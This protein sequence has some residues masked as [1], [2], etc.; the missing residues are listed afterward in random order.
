MLRLIFLSLLATGLLYAQLH[1]V[2]TTTTM[3][4]L[5]STVGGDRVKVT[6]LAS[7]DRDSHFLQARPSMMRDLRSAD[8]VVSVGAELEVGWLP[9][10][11]RGA[12]NPQ[13]NPGNPGYFE[14]ASQVDL[15]GAGQ[16]A[17]RAMGDVHPAGNPHINLDPV[18]LAQ[19][20][21][22]LAARLGALDPAGREPYR[23]NA[24]AFDEAVQQ[25]LSGWKQK[26]KGANGVLLY[27]K[28][29]NYLTSR[30]GVPVLGYVEPLPGIPPTAA[31][32]HDLASRLSGQKGAVLHAV[33]QP[34]QSSEFV[35]KQL[36]WPVRALP[37]DPPIGGD[38]EA[39]F[40][41]I[42]AWVDAMAL[43]K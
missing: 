37:T 16:A 42:D 4:M 20:A 21:M 32:L 18:R 26:L 29:A 34:A 15:I 31:H 2:A 5:A 25:R 43:A 6:V 11:I 13:I 3:Q 17:D 19:A 12:A 14:A 39:Y 8:L 35:G 38:K 33:Y 9:A 24:L 23:A 30:F 27:H 1:V 40:K 36:G 10:A 7:P 22:M 41:V 28:D